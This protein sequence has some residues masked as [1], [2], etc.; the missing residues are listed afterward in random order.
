ME[1]LY[2]L[3]NIR[4]P[5]LNK[6]LLAITTLGEETA[7]LVIGL[8]MFWCVSKQK[9]YFLLCIGLMGTVVNQLLKLIFRV[10]RPWVRDPAFTIV[11][12]ARAEATGY[13]FPSG[14]TQS[15]TTVLGCTARMLRSWTVRIVLMVLIALTAFSRMYLGVHTPADVG[16]SLIAGTIMVF[17]F[18][19]LFAHADEKPAP[20]YASM[21]ALLV[22]SIAYV[23]FCEVH[24]W[25]ADM[26][27]ENMAHGIENGYLLMGCSTA[28]LLS[29]YL[30]R[31]YIRFEVKASLPVQI[32]KVVI[33]LVL[34][35]AIKEGTKPVLNLIFH[36]HPI[37]RA[38]RYFLM[39][40]FAACVW[41]LTFKYFGK[42]RT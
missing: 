35:M 1:F 8:I 9:G 33:G 20:M 34:V 24:A 14:H 36:G 17:A 19:P 16:V 37:A 31:R 6:L 39:V 32:L 15:V 25:P 38:I 29:C 30:E 3:E 4:V 40:M 10:P 13:S 22:L 12:S 26:D 21:A 11:E 5:F 28:L 27:P 41:P 18:Y 2:I 42:K 7:F 23:I